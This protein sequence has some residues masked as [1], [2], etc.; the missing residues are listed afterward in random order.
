MHGLNA[1]AGIE[2]E[3]LGLA[4]GSA[5]APIFDTAGSTL[6]GR[7]GLTGFAGLADLRGLCTG[8]FFSTTT[9]ALPCSPSAIIAP[10]A[11]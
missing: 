3:M 11:A 5:N 8:C 6:T 7:T 1:D 10:H 9:G 4:N 2:R